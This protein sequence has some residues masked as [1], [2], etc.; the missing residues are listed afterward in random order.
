MIWYQRNSTLFCQQL[1]KL[2]V[3]RKFCWKQ[4]SV[5]PVEDLIL[6][7]ILELRLK[8]ATEATSTIVTRRYRWPATHRCEYR[9]WPY[10]TECRHRQPSVA[11]G[12]LGCRRKNSER[13]N[14]QFLV[15]VFIH[16]YAKDWS[17]ANYQTQKQILIKHF[18]RFESFK[19]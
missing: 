11:D 18:I 19:F 3:D 14:C 4:I 12:N 15:K 2:I 9:W 17:T 5:Y 1:V 7:A 10:V 16:F 13:T 6:A 8:S